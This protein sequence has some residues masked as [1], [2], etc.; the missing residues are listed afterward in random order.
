MLIDDETMA[1]PLNCIKRLNTTQYFEMI[2][3][4]IIPECS[5]IEL[6][7]GLM[8]IKDRS[9]QG[10]DP[11]SIGRLHNLLVQLFGRLNAELALYGCSLQLQGPIELSDE[12]VPEPDAA[13]IKGDPDDYQDRLP[14]AKDVFSLIEIADASL[15]YDRTSKLRIYANAGI[16][17]FVIVNVV[18]KQ[19][20]VFE[21]PQTVRGTYAKRD[22]FKAG[23]SVP[24]F[25]GKRKRFSVSVSKLMR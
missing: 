7:D 20:E 23:E 1:I 14:R 4:G 12:L 9:A 13:I 6:I 5:P 8:V 3:T 19:I 10:E 16:S 2:K 21:S 15:S 17:Q 11:R 22:V 24:F 25:V 18:D